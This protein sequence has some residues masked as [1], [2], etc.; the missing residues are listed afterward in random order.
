MCVSV[1]PLSSKAKNRFCNLMSRNPVCTVEQDLGDRMF[2]RS[3]DDTY[4][5]WVDLMGDADWLVQLP[6]CHMGQS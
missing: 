5:F 2:L 3:A 6:K 1:K 4:W